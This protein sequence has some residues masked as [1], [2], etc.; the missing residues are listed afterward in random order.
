[1]TSLLYIAGMSFTRFVTRC[2]RPSAS[3]IVWSVVFFSLVVVEGAVAK[4]VQLPE[5]VRLLLPVAPM[6]AGFF[7]MRSA[8]RDTRRQS[9]ELQ[10]RIYLEAAAVAL[11][12]LFVFV[13]T[14]PLMQA[15]GWVGPLQA[16]AVLFAL[17]GFGAIG[18]FVARRRYR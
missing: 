13:L 9:D 17:I 16:E 8:V 15:A 12:G 1:M 11:C 2:G 6:V 3:Q 10:L 5:A 7:Y 4:R 14:Y 18:Y